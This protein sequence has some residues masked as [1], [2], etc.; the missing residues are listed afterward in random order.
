VSSNRHV[1]IV[2]FPFLVLGA[3]VHAYRLGYQSLW[4]DEIVTVVNSNGPLFE[5][6]THP[7]INPMKSDAATF[8]SLRNR[9]R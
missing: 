6:L 4:I 2:V 1:A 9:W 8:R 7:E 3:S 5:V